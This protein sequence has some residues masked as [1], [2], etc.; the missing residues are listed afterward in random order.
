MD[1][2]LLDRLYNRRFWFL[3][4]TTIGITVFF[5]AKSVEPLLKNPPQYSIL[6]PAQI[7]G[8]VIF[9]LFMI[10]LAIDEIKVKK[11]AE[12]REALFDELYR[13]YQFK[14]CQSGFITAIVASFFL[15]SSTHIPTASACNIILL[16]TSLG[17]SIPLLIYMKK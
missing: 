2:K 13:Q 5:G 9:L 11:N 8:F 3:L 10:P 16:A 6:S 15:S 4:G 1:M 17:A 7:V 14:A 12:L